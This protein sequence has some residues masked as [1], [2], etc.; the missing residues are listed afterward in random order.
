M[1]KYKISFSLV[2]LLCILY[3][4]LLNAQQI[5]VADWENPELTSFNTLKPHVSYI[6]FDTETKA[7]KN[8]PGESTAYLSLNG[9][10]KFKLSDN[11]TL[12]PEGFFKPGFDASSW[13]LIDVPS[14]W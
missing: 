8:I 10:W 3:S 6:P 4:N 9:K 1:K 7:I 5:S 11:Y 13:A 2:M 14:T 12:V